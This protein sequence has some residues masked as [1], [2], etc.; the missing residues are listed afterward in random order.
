MGNDD[1]FEIVDGLAE[2]REQHGVGFAD[3]GR[4]RR[5]PETEAAGTR[6]SKAR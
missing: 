4:I 1:D 6:S 2:Q 5:T 3:R